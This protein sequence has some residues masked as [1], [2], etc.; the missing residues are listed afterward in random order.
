VSRS[1]GSRRSAASW[2]ARAGSR[3]A[4]RDGRPGPERPAH[5][6]RGPHKKDSTSSRGCLSFRAPKGTKKRRVALFRAARRPALRRRERGDGPGLTRNGCDGRRP[7]P[8]SSAAARC[9]STNGARDRQGSRAGQREGL[10]RGRYDAILTN[11]PA[12]APSCATTASSSTTTP[13][14]GVRQAHRDIL[15]VPGRDRGPPPHLKAVGQGP[16]YDEPCHCSTRRRS[17]R[18]PA[19][20][21]PAGRAS[22]GGPR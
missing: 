13:P 22:A 21:W 9:T 8:R 14:Q 12:A 7:H 1:W 16:A 5:S 17:A 10:Q 3:E 15:R 2:A 4:R 19:A 20:R 6:F 18:R 11:A